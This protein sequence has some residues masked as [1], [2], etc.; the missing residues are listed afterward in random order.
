M[1]GVTKVGEPW[2]LSGVDMM[3][4]LVVAKV[5]APPFN[6]A[7]ARRACRGGGVF[8]EHCICMAFTSKIGA[9][10]APWLP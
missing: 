1:A 5:H 2:R 4:I 10:V 6:C 7:A 9:R 3:L 8:G